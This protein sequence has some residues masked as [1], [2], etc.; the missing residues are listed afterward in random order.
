MKRFADEEDANPAVEP[1]VDPV[2]VEDA[3]AIVLPHVRDVAVIVIHREGATCPYRK[4]S[5]SPPFEAST[6]LSRSHN[7]TVEFYSGPLAHQLPIPSI[8]SL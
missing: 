7:L 5:E 8:F 3:L 1:V 2:V 4:P 6:E